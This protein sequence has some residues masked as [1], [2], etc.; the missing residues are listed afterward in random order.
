LGTGLS[1]DTSRSRANA[2]WA[3]VRRRDNI[4]YRPR[5]GGLAHGRGGHAV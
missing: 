2:N 4:E 3:N 1:L 5:G